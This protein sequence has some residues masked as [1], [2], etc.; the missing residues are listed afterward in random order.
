M[1]LN[2]KRGIVTL[3]D[4]A[5]QYILAEATQ[6]LSL[7]SELPVDDEDDKLRF[8]NASL[9]RSQG[10]SAAALEP[11]QYTAVN[12]TQQHTGQALVINDLT[13]D[14]RYKDHATAGQGV[15]FYS[16][17]PIRCK[18][19]YHI[20]VYT[21]T[22]DKPRGGL[23]PSELI[24]MQDMAEIVMCH[25]ELVY[26]DA[27]GHRGEQLVTGLGRFLEGK[28]SMRDVDEPKS[29]TKVRHSTHDADISST[30]STEKVTGLFKGMS[31]TN[32]DPNLL[33]DV[34]ASANQVT[35]QKS[36]D[37]IERDD[38]SGSDPSRAY[39]QPTSHRKSDA[40]SKQNSTNSKSDLQSVGNTPKH[41]KPAKPTKLQ[42]VFG[43]AASILRGCTAADGVIFYDAS[44]TSVS[45]P[46][47]NSERNKGN[48]HS[49]ENATT[50]DDYD[51]SVAP[52][53]SSAL[54]DSE[55]V[56]RDPQMLTSNENSC[57]MLGYALD[58]SA[59][60]TANA[61]TIES[62]ALSKRGLARFIKRYPRG[63]VF[64]FT[65][66]GDISASESQAGGCT[67]KRG[68]LS[69]A[70][71]EIVGRASG[72]TEEA[73]ASELIRT[74][75]G[76]RSIIWLPLWDFN[77]RRWCAGTFLW[78]RRAE[79]LLA[80]QDDLTYLKTFGNSIM[81]NVSRLDAQ[82]ADEA[83][84]TFIA[85]ISHELRSPLH[86]ILGSTEFL[87]ET[88]LDGFQS[89]M[90]HAVE[91]CAK[92]LLD[93]VEHV[94]DYS[95]INQMSNRLPR[96]RRQLSSK[97]ADHESSK[98]S[99][100][101]SSL[102]RDV[103][104]ADL[105]E[106]AVE[107]VYAGQT[108]R[109][110][111]ARHLEEIADAFTHSPGASTGEIRSNVEEG[112]NKFAGA[113][114]VILELRKCDN[115]WVRT[116]PG[117]IRRIVMNI[118]GNSLKYTDTGIILVSMTSDMTQ[119]Y[120]A[121]HNAVCIK[122]KD[123]GQGMSADFLRHHAFTPFS[124]ESYLSAGTGLGLSIVH[125]IVDSLSG[126]IEVASEK[127]VGTEI[128]IF[129]NI[130]SVPPPA[131]SEDVSDIL[132]TVSQQTPGL[133]LCILDPN[134]DEAESLN[135]DEADKTVESA[136]RNV[137]EDWLGMRTRKSKSME[138]TTADFFVYAEP[139]PISYLL[140]Q[141]GHPATA[142]EVP[143]I[144]MATNAFE[145]ASLAANGI[146]HLT[147]VGRIM[148]I[149][150]QP[151][152]P[153]KLARALYRCLQRV[154]SF[155]KSP[156]EGSDTEPI[157]PNVVDSPSNILQQED[158]SSIEISS[159]TNGPHKPTYRPKS[160]DTAT[161]SGTLPS[162]AL[163]HPSNDQHP[164][165]L[166]S[167]G[168]GSQKSF[169]ADEDFPT[170]LLVEDNDVN[171]SLLVAF[172]KKSK[173]SYVTAKDGLQATQAFEKFVAGDGKANHLKYIVMDISMPIMDGIEATRIIRRQEK[174]S[175][176]S[177]GVVIIALT[178][179]GA[180]STRQAMFDAGADYYL[181]KPVKFKELMEFFHSR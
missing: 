37:D 48:H 113:V 42:K 4:N 81:M 28:T 131:P 65:E 30:A 117:A 83:K 150:S 55:S 61:P 138:N 100:F 51:T 17:V 69:S 66:T 68:D 167:Q 135:V 8:G 124:Q 171:L 26:A 153:H 110:P 107:A 25:L 108:F 63:K 53:Y 89:S 72:V 115:W 15:T 91:T 156:V 14:D 1:R 45:N 112:S 168:V 173:L 2:A 39:D 44:S 172:M 95:K 160:R 22:D 134:L 122:V 75:P 179:L 82:S 145:S 90:T 77:K 73:V 149:I 71:E 147:D 126:R 23:K 99:I 125:Q 79:R 119:P 7:R 86:G 20:G 27:A 34:Q 54:T 165:T 78:S 146:N 105:F 152:G 43:R 178:G 18:A 97:G 141:H 169:S 128:K 19:G 67:M 5:H 96:K 127:G 57:E 84:S 121:T 133:C 16:G 46:R 10:I 13:R 143:L 114:R 170:V 161:A 181:T 163:S 118:L 158:S 120:N 180:E 109:S 58:M 144:I 151:C 130:P 102:E 123:T 137:A 47:G 101:R 154:R 70:V 159:Q 11:P 164:S 166:G 142:K 21:I 104:L 177:E 98:S 41:I 140:R 6:S 33:R 175:N 139:P 49:D 36:S 64:Y 85:S 116:Q 60:S 155:E 12:E 103:N 76:A 132:T 148:E 174:L 88:A 157:H 74:M 62:L 93:T 59:A 31:I 24:F 87:Q 3:I 80:I 92:T 111:A 94:L 29:K 136:L 40:P 38:V 52:D 50:S 56:D 176:V 106:E 32:A 162:K 9:P 35:P 129:L